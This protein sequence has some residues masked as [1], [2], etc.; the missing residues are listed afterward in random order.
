VFSWAH[1]LSLYGISYLDCLLIVIVGFGGGCAVDIG[2]EGVG[3]CI[4]TA[5]LWRSLL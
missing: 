4:N 5:L 3:K 2:D 1:L